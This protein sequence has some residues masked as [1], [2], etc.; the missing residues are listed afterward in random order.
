[1]DGIMGI[2][3]SGGLEVFDGKKDKSTTNVKTVEWGVG[4][5]G[6]GSYGPTRLWNIEAPGSW[7]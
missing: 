7:T 2:Q 3:L 5:A 6:Y 1:M 4:L